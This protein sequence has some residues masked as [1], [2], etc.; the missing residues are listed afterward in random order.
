MAQPMEVLAQ[1][2][3]VVRQAKK[4]TLI[5]QATVKTEQEHPAP[6]RLTHLHRPYLALSAQDIHSGGS[7]ARPGGGTRGRGSKDICFFLFDFNNV[8][9]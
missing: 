9:S 3:E 1:P 2:M 7:T 6:P 5:R 4:K 8:R